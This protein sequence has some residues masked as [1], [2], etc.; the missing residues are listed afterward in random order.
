[1]T[2]FWH[3]PIVRGALAGLLAA[4]AV[5][6]AAFRVWKSFQDARSY[7]WSLAL[8]RWVQGAVIGA[9]SGGGFLLVS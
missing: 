2:E 8:W 6:F 9:V 7:H 4:A 5:D 3:S 1:M